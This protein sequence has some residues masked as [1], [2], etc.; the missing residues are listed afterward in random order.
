MLNQISV[1]VKVT[2]T[3]DAP[4]HVGGGK[5]GAGTCSYLVRDGSG[6]PHWPGS[7]FKGKVRHYARL[8]YE[9]SGE[10]C[11]HEHKLEE[12]DAKSCACLVCQMLGGAGNARGS[13]LFGDMRPE[14]VEAAGDMRAGN[15]IDRCRRTANDNSLFQIETAGAAADALTGVI[16]GTLS[17]EAFDRQCGLLKA[18]IEAIPH[19]GGNTGRGLGWVKDIAVVIE[20]VGTKEQFPEKT[21]Y[22]IITVPVTITARS[23]LLIG[24]KTAQSNFRTTQAVIPGAVLRAGLAQALIAQDGGAGQQGR[25]NWVDAGGGSGR[26][27]TLRRVFDDLRITQCLPAG[28]RVAP[29]TAWA[30]KFGCGKY[31]CDGQTHDTLHEPLGVCPTCGAPVERAGGFLDGRGRRVEKPSTMVVSKSAMNRFSGTSQDEMLFS[32]EVITPPVVFE[33]A[34][35]GRFDPVELKCLVKDGIRVG[36]YQTA[37]Y[38]DC[39]I[40]IGN[41]VDLTETYGQLRA[42]IRDPKCI[43]VTLLS[44]AMVALAFP[45]GG[46]YLEAYRKALFPRLPDTLRLVKALAR[47]DQWRGFDTSKHRGYLNPA[48]HVVKAGAVFVLETDELRDDA[49]DALL[50]LQENGVCQGLTARNGYGQV[51]VADEY[52]DLREE[53]EVAT[54]ETVENKRRLDRNKPE[55]IRRAQA[56]LSIKFLPEKRQPEKRQFVSL[57]EAAAQAVCVEELTLFIRYKKSKEGSRSGWNDLAD[58]LVKAIEG[59]KDLDGGH[60]ELTRL[61]LG[62]LMWERSTR[63]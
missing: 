8:L 10:I 19:I 55:L 36:G 47:H 61:F 52:H 57:V 25:R 7:A 4:F 9:G 50:E 48:A 29:I 58:P 28:S 16:T 44:D 60:L 15:A 37:G 33:G 45:E 22:P 54:K 62:Y 39:A 1:R 41:P 23:P 32:M 38:G 24:T 26:Y 13:L 2:L 6:A 51:R 21:E 53:P 63:G 46:D 27:P 18:A 43:T 34:I 5:G 40:E 59:L 49:L 30:C 56:V 20:K 42:R 3:L 35:T 31:K 12:N 11:G 14:A 17:G